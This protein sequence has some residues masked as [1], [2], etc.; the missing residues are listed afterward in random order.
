MNKAQRRALLQAVIHR[1]D[2]LQR[3]HSRMRAV[4]WNES[5]PAYF[6]TL[7]AFEAMHQLVK[8]MDVDPLDTRP[9]WMKHMNS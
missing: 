1:R 2:W 5:D 4:G 8:A 9:D 7:N 3:L 6:V